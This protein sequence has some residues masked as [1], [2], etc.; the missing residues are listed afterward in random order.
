MLR[1]ALHCPVGGQIGMVP[2]GAAESSGVI[3]GIVYRDAGAG[4]PA[5]NL[6]P[7]RQRHAG[8]RLMICRQGAGLHLAAGRP[9]LCAK[10]KNRN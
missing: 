6:N 9:S 8:G 10:K 4:Q 1:E 2:A 5:G 3:M 7:G